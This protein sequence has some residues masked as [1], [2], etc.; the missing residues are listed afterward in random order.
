MKTNSPAVYTQPGGGEYKHRDLQVVTQG[1]VQ[2]LRFS[3]TSFGE[4]WQD[5][6]SSVR[7]IKLTD[8]EEAE[9]NIIQHVTWWM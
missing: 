8:H 7:T 4:N 5:G 2:N 3:K 9:I 6:I 1:T